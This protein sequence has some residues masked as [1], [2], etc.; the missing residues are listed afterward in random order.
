M[1]IR[2]RNI[3]CIVIRFT[4]T[5]AVQAIHTVINAS[6]SERTTSQLSHA[7]PD[8]RVYGIL[9]KRGCDQ[10]LGILPSN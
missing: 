10:S 6:R 2:I 7:A 4:Q 8:T 1:Q 9:C 5:S 3:G